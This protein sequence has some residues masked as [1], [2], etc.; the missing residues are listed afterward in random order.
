MN[1]AA[2][3]YHDV[4]PPGLEETS[5]FPGGDAGRYKLTTSQFE[6]HLDAIARVAAPR[7]IFTFDDGGVSAVE[8]IAGRLEVRGLRGHFFITTGYIGLQ[9]FLTR[10]QIRELAE[11]GHTIGSHSHTHPLRMALCSPDQL[12]REWTTSLSLLSD[13][14]GTAIHTASVPG[15]H[16]SKAVGDAARAAGI[17]TLF[18]SEPTFERRVRPDSDLVVVGRFA[19]QRTTTAA[20][21]AAL[22]AGRRLARWRHAAVWNLKTVAKS[23]GGRRYLEVRDR[24]LGGGQVKWGE[25][26][27]RSSKDP[28]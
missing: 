22:V 13:I 27:A 12:A 18:T 1:I 10:S 8:F 23:L 26:L 5:G 4:T 16:Y 19:I 7:P 11:R 6:Q 21:A 9:G 28:S 14:V 25:E 2:L 3:M 20:T 24:L 17:R 15:G